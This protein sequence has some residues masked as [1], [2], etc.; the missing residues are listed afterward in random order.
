M[1][2]TEIPAPTLVVIDVAAWAA[3]H[4]LTGYYVHRLRIERLQDDNWLFARRGFERDGRFYRDTLRIAR[5][6]DRLP[7][8]GALFPG[9][10]TKRRLPRA[11]AGGLERFIVETRRAELGH[12]LAIAPAPLFAL[13]NPPAV[14]VVMVVYA[15]GVN[16]PFIA[17]QRYNR[18]RAAGAAYSDPGDPERPPP[19]PATRARHHRH[20][21]P[22]RLA[23]EAVMDAMGVAEPTEIR[24]VGKGDPK[25]SVD[26]DLVHE[27]V[28]AAVEGDP[29]ARPAQRFQTGGHRR[30]GE[31]R[32]PDRREAQ[33]EQIV[34]LEAT[35]RRHVVAAMPG[36]AGAVHQ[37]A[38][39]G[40]RHRLHGDERSDH[41]HNT[42]HR[43]RLPARS[44]IRITSVKRAKA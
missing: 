10:I 6:K 37:P 18:L 4:S 35:A 12:W 11:E 1:P 3:I 43:A 28:G 39:G 30:G 8:A 24:P 27:Q 31:Q 25:P 13:I 36:H 19:A 20:E 26:H 15:V 9:G 41:E 2:L 42:D 17:I 14:A 34:A 38:V 44:Q 5:W 16:L 21:H 32:H 40:V 23:A 22:V 29:D 7:E 33:R